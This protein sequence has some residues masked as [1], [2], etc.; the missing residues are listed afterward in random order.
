VAAPYTAA[1]IAKWFIAWAEGEGVDLSNLKLQKLLYFAQGHHFAMI[2]GPLFDDRMEA[3]SHGPVVPSVYRTYKEFESSDLEL[4]DDDA[5]S[6]DDVDDATTQLLIDVWERYGIYSAWYLRDLAHSQS[7]WQECW[8]EDEDYIE[9][10][11]PA[12]ERFF[13]TVDA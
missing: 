9:I 12:I 13:S 7:P 10:T 2:G 11:K 8:R 3:W 4:A 1:L 5:F 6:W